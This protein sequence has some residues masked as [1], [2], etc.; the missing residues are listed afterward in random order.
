MLFPA[1]S[2]AVTEVCG[3]MGSRRNR[4]DPAQGQRDLTSTLHAIAA[5]ATLEKRAARAARQAQKASRRS[6]TDVGLT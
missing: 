2:P 3:G 1:S 5:D 6:P 4:A